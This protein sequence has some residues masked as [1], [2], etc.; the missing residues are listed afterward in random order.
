MY[1]FSVSCLFVCYVFGSSPAFPANPQGLGTFQS[2]LTPR[3]LQEGKELGNSAKTGGRPKTDRWPGVC[4]GGNGFVFTGFVVLFAF[5]LSKSRNRIFF[6]LPGF[7]SNS[8]DAWCSSRSKHMGERCRGSPMSR[9][10][11]RIF[12]GKNSLKTCSE[13]EVS[14]FKEE[15]IFQREAHWSWT[16]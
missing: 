1:E 10:V 11:T 6:F 7:V 16:F 9:G 14:P 8:K 5:G 13:R 12:E 2:V 3:S 4:F 15:N